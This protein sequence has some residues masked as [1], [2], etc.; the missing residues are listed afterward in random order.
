MK[1]GVVSDSSNPAYLVNG[2]ELELDFG[3]EP[4]FKAGLGMSFSYDKWDT[5]AEYTWFRGTDTVQID[6]SSSGG[7][8]YLLPAFTIPS[9]VNPRYTFG[10]ENWKLNLNF[11]DW[12]LRRSCSLGTS[13]FL[14]PFV[15]L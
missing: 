4:G 5:F 8:T 10:S 3:F 11:L 7:V 14:R 1:L 9:V 13:L 15:G 2:Y 6:L 12:D